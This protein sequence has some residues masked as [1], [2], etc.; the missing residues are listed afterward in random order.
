MR[1]KFSTKEKERPLKKK[2][3]GKN[4]KNPN[5]EKSK[6]QVMKKNC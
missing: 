6:F 4:K 2:D 5:L 3:E 1:L